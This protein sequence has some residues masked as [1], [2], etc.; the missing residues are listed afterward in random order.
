MWTRLFTMNKPERPQFVLGI[1]FTLLSGCCF[2]LCGLILGEFIDV[3]ANPD[4]DDFNDKRSI[5]AVYFIVI[6]VIGFFLN[7]LKFYYFTRVGE[8][9]TL[10]VR[11]E[12]LKKM[13]RMPGGWFD[14]VENNPGTLSARLASDAHLV[15]N[16]TSNVVQ[17]QVNNFS[18]FLTGFL[19]AFI[20]SW[21]VALVAVAVCPFIVI[22]GTIRA[23]KVQGFSEG[24]D[25]A[26]KD[27]GMIIMEAVTNIRTVASFSNEKK[28]SHFLSETLKNP[29][30]I[31]FRKGHVSGVSLGFS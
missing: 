27:S 10:R 6:G 23:R 24:S 21:R 3:L 26:Y 19:V 22:A 16:L 20:Y 14:R 7:I 12:L 18:A 28:L 31:A 8:G 5:L 25:K 30:Q 29:Y 9:L 2:P 17:V 4:S 13:L 1:I 15:N 11:Q